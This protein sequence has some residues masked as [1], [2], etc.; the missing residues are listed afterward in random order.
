MGHDNEQI[1]LFDIFNFNPIPGIE[2]YNCNRC[3][4][5][6]YK[7][8]AKGFIIDISAVTFLI[9]I[10]FAFISAKKEYNK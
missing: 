8:N 3:Q 6:N 1:K 9:V 10:I 2:K 4:E 7:F 5:I